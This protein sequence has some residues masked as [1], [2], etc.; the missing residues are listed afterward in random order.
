MKL[1]SDRPYLL[2]RKFTSDILDNKTDEIKRAIKNKELSRVFENS[3]N[4][5]A[6]SSI[7]YKE[8]DGKP[9]TFITSGDI[10]ALSLRDSVIQIW[11]YLE[12]MNDDPAFKKLAEGLISRQTDCI[13][14]DSY[15]SSFNEIH[16][17]SEWVKDLTDMKPGVYE[18]KWAVDS[19]CYFVRLSYHFWKL[20]GE[21]NCFD[22]KWEKAVER[23][24]NTFV[25]QQRKKSRG[26]Y[27]FGRVTHNK[28]DTVAGEGY[29]NPINPIGMICSIFRP[30]DDAAIF[31]FIISSNYFAVLSLRQLAEMLIKIRKNKELADKLT[32]LADEI[33]LS[34]SKYAVGENQLFGKIFAYEIDGFGSRVFMDDGNIPSLLS[35]AYLGCMNKNDL[36][37]NN[38]RNYVLSKLNPYYFKGKFGRGI[39]SPHLG[40][41]MV[42]S[43]GVIMRA[44]TSNDD[45]EIIECINT[46]VNSANGTGY[47]FESFDKDNPKKNVR[48][49]YAKASAMFAEL[50]IKLYSERKD[51]LKEL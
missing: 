43:S 19:L 5:A 32:A 40:V 31:P 35:L 11:N 44:I 6:D 48:P 23:I 27:T 9:D 51:L 18:R 33:N 50:I 17:K 21:T 36:L 45:D 14:I 42:S 25:E 26:S 7:F 22:G 3:F 37:Y 4:Y 49:R 13:L 30:S 46:L 8:I 16:S 34:L 10:S 20:S 39:G 12:F 47:L 38:T 15:A 1:K 29:G 2:D 24:F 41:G 28:T